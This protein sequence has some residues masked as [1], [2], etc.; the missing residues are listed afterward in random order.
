MF[1]KNYWMGYDGNPI[2]GPFGYTDPENTSSS[3][4]RV[5][6]G[7]TLN[8]SKIIDRPDGF[9][10]GFFV[11]DYEFTD[12]GDLDQYNGRFAK[13]V[14]FPEGVYA[15]YA[16]LDSSNNPQFPYFIG[17]KYRSNT[18]PENIS[19]NQT[20]DFNSSDLLRN[21]FPY[22]VSD[23]FAD[24]DFIIETNEVVN[25]KAIVESQSTGSIDNF[26]IINSGSGYEVGDI[27]NFDTTETG[28]GLIAKISRVKGK[29]IDNINTTVHEFN[30]SIFTL[31]DDRTVKITIAPEHTILDNDSVIISG[32]STNLT[33]LNDSFIV[34]VTSFRTNLTEDISAGTSGVSTEIYVSQIPDNI[35]VDSRLGIGTEV[36]T[37]LEVFDNLN[38]LKVER[39]VTGLSHTASTT[40]FFKPDTLTIKSNLEFFD[41]RVNDKVYFNPVE[42]VGV[43]T[44]AG[45]SNSVSFSFGNSVVTRDIPT[46]S[47]TLENHPFK[48]N[49]RVVFNNGGG[50]NI[51]ISTSPTGSAFN[52]PSNV[53]V[54]DKNINSIGIKTTLSSSEVYF[55]TNGSDNDKY[56][57]ESDFNQIK[58]NIQKKRYS[59]I[60]IHL[61]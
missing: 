47:I 49:Q 50:S 9:D 38:I 29:N 58:G 17:N 5:Q 54:V 20:F 18:L 27:L 19:L 6:S 32:F 15:Y 60:N 42:S 34:G 56:F 8:T 53:F 30:D 28:G 43:G 14:E 26:D 59:S 25:Q 37:V 51:S 41:S 11:D 39:G 22:K 33:E 31:E 57:F 55:R 13:T 2:Y 46:R 1:L 52:L 44:T 36:L 23:N 10:A 12:S 3:P 21:T 7:Y 24:N 45:V 61:P 48:N 40:V 4:K 35:S 16:T